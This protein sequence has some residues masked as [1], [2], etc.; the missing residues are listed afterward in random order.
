MRGFILLLVAWCVGPAWGQEFNCGFFEPEGSNT[1]RTVGTITSDSD[2]WSGTVKPLILFG[3]LQGAPDRALTGL[4]DREGSTNPGQSMANFLNS[5]HEGSL[6]HFFKEMSYETLSLVPP[7]GGV[8]LTWSESNHANLTGYG[9]ISESQCSRSIWGAGIKQFV[10]E[11]ITNADDR[12]NFRDYDGN[13]DGVVDLILVVTPRAFGDT[14]GYHGTPL[15]NATDQVISGM[16]DGVNVGRI[17]TSDYRASM[18]FFA[19]VFAHE[20]GHTMGLPELFDRTHHNEPNSTMD[21]SAGIGYWGVMSRLNWPHPRADLANTVSGASLFSVYSRMKVGW[22]TRDNDRLATIPSDEL[23]ITIYDINS[24]TEGQRDKAYKIPVN[25]SSTEYFLVANRQNQHSEESI[26]SYYNDFARGSGLAIWHIDENALGKGGSDVNEYEKHKRVDLEC[27]DGLFSDQGYPSNMPDAV[28]GGDNLDYWSESTSY[29]KNGNEG[30]ATDLWDGSSYSEFTPDTNPSTA[31]YAAQDPSVSRLIDS[32]TKQQNVFSGIYIENIAAGSNGVM[33]FDVRFAPLAPNSLE[34]AVGENQVEL[35]W[36]PP[37]DNGATIASYKVRHRLS[38]EQSWTETLLDASA[39][40]YTVTGLTENEYTFEVLAIS[41]MQGSNAGKEGL[42]ARTTATPQVAMAGPPS[43]RFD[44]NSEDMVGTYQKS[45]LFDWSLEGIDA[46]RFE[47]EGTGGSRELHFQNP[48]DFE[49]PLDTPDDGADRGD[50]IYH[51]T[52]KATPTGATREESDRYMKAV[53]VRVLDVEE[54]GK[55]TVKPTRARVDGTT[56]PPRQGEE[57]TATLTDPDGVVSINN[58]QWMRRGQH[59]PGSSKI[60]GATSLTYT[61]VARDVGHVLQAMAKYTDVRGPNKSSSSIETSVVVGRP[62]NPEVLEPVVGDGQ[63]TLTW[64]KPSDGGSPITGYE[65]QQSNDGGTIWGSEMDVDCTDETCSKELALT[66]GLYAFGVRAVNVVGLSDWVRTGPIRISALMVESQGSN[67]ELAFAEVVSGQTRSLVVETYTA[68]GVADG[69]T[70]GWSLAGA[71]VGVFTISGGVLRFATAPDY[72]MPTDASHATDED[73]N[74]VYHVTVQATAGEQTATLVVQ[75]EVTNADDPGEVTLSSTQPEVGETITATLTDP[76][77]SV[78][79]VRWSWSYFSS[80]DSPRNGEPTVVSSSDEFIPSDVLMGLR[81]QARALYADGLGTHQSAESVQTEPVVGRPSAPQNLTATPSDGS[82]VLAWDAPSLVGYPAFSGYRYRY[83][84][85]GTGWLPSA[86]GALVDQTTRPTLEEGLIH[87]KEHTV[88]VW[89]VNA[90]G[91]GPS[92]TTTATPPS[93]DTPGRVELTSRRPRVGVPLTATLVDP[94]APVRVRRWRWLQSPW[95]Y[96]SAGDS[97]LVAPSEVRYPE[98]ASYEP[99]VSAIGR[100]LRAVVDYTDQYGTPSAQSAWTAPV[101][102]GWPKAPALSATAG[103]AQVALTWTAAADQGAAIIRYQYHRSDKSGKWLDVPGDGL[104]GRYTVG[105][106]TNDADYTFKVRAVNSA[107]EGSPSNAVTAT[108]QGP[109]DPNPHAPAIAGPEEVSVAEGHIGALA[110]ATYTTSDGDDDAVT[111]TL[112]DADRG[113]FSLSSSGTLRVTSALDY[114]SDDTRYEVT[115]EAIDDGEPSKSSTKQVTVTVDNVDEVGTVTLSDPSPQ[116]GDHL[117]ATLSD[118]DGGIR[119][120][121]WYWQDISRSDESDAAEQPRTT[122]YPYTVEASDEGRRIE[123]RASYTDAHGSGKTARATT[124]VVQEAAESNRY[125]PEIAGPEE[126]SVAE[127][128]TGALADAT[129]TTSD[130]DDDQVTLTLTDADRGPFSLSSSGTLQVTSALDFESDDTR[131]EVTLEA[132]DDGEPSKSSTK[133]VTVTV[134]NQEEEGTIRLSSSSPQVGD[135]LTATLSDP[136]GG[137]RNVSWYWQDIPRSDESDAAEQPR[138]T[139]Y[140]YTVEASDEG[141][142]IEVRASYTDAHGSS[143]SARATTEVVQE[144]AESNRYAPAISGPEEVSVAEGH[145]GALADATYTTS[146]GDDDQVTLTLTD[147]DRG[148]FSLSSSGA[149]RVT[150]ALDYERDDT[151]YTVTLTATDD[152]TPSKSSTK[153]V[154]VTVTNV[155]EAGTVSLTSSSPQVGDRLTASLSDPDGYQSGGEWDWQL[156]YRQGDGDDASWVRDESVRYTADSY[157]V[158][159]SDAGRRLRAVISNYT[160]GHGSGKSAHSALTEPVQES[161]RY[162]PVISGSGSVSIN[163]GTTGSLAD[164][165]TS[166]GDGDDVTLTLTNADG[167]PFSLSSSGALRL[168]SALD[169]ESDDTRYEVTL[170]ATDDGTPSKSSTKRVEVTVD[171][172]DEAG[173][174]SLTSSS[175]RVG[176]RLTASLSDPDGYQ[177]GGSWQWLQFHGGRDGDDD[178]WEEDESVRYAADRYTV[179]SSAVGRRLRA[180]ISG[181]TDGHGSGKSAQSS[182][183]TTVQESNR[184]EPEIS[185]S[186]SVSIN[187]GTTGSLA[188]YTTSDGDGD[189]VTL[190]LT[191]ADGGPFSLSSSGALRLTSALDYERDD[192]SYTVTLTA[193]DDGTPSKSST[194]SV[195]VSIRNVDEAGTV[196]LTS[197]SPRVGD[198]LTASLSDPDGYQSGGSWQWLQ[199]RGGRDGDDDSWEEDESVRYAADRYTVPSSAVGRRLRARISGYTDGHGSG[200][201]A[202]SSLTTTVRANEPGSPG[203]FTAEPGNVYTRVDLSWS[204]AVANGSAITRYEYRYKAPSGSWSSWT[205]VGV[206]YS[207]TVSGLS[208]G[209][210]YSFEV[211]AVNGEGAGPSSSTS[212]LVRTPPAKPVSLQA[213]PDTVLSAV[214]AP[215]PFNPT[216]TIHLQVPMRGVVWLTIYNV[217]GQVVR[218]LLDDYELDAGYHSVDWDGRDQQGQPVTSGV[219][220][221]HLRAGTQ[222]LVHKLL[223]LR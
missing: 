8:D 164:Y 120:V 221:Y 207:T 20:Y 38:T 214:A 106:L 176:D 113:P 202:Q 173:T 142:R 179:P 178:S 204:A 103:D 95:Y 41:A 87:G 108:P 86:T 155:D 143:K 145:T 223:L 16:L 28:N 1:V 25:G 82:L 34:A 27:A 62:G 111:L 19:S 5:D 134:T 109:A 151:S 158:Q 172:V 123:V 23:G 65:Y 192:T 11:V 218:T 191:N 220:L 174:V 119:N 48:P 157:T 90:Q 112:T 118:P 61:P 121:S 37:S 138:T 76:D 2:Y 140:P 162:E 60:T 69:T 68:S 116:V 9:I 183:T 197:S 85:K 188:D 100:R 169:Y 194:K 199:F 33:T 195:S 83:K 101:Q 80:E 77:G 175:P 31:G 72:E 104:D 137:I 136:D 15:E 91:A 93:P 92:A 159:A 40:S 46:V 205:S 7:E 53:E 147:A 187:E 211:R 193:T 4:Q 17:I 213:L 57:L 115:L 206:A 14:C 166:D 30:D 126:V 180:R 139:S 117:T 3:K 132:I 154:A 12:I 152:G 196:S 212:S 36:K 182:L 200:K 32:S 66:P 146:D 54:Y 26:G 78:E 215:N 128:H 165:T 10:E 127:G 89:A 189:D 186:G 170:T 98:L 184:Y 209:Q 79:N 64:R 160:D 198:R 133:Q 153:Q 44:E 59:E 181:Y 102:P 51:V 18:P 45:G 88:E 144:A 22:I 129:Y 21:H 141:R 55:V 131:Y 49:N 73:G 210:R 94:D 125:A 70:V 149:L 58:W 177:S 171:N 135:H 124:E 208:S 71:D 185:G 148:P 47:L 29:N 56:S 99:T 168:T 6:A 43:V 52:V 63:V 81:L 67:P 96:R 219:Y 222:A 201:S 130:G 150:S 163:E 110:D 156:W 216:T 190:T 97:S 75:V 35:T 24:T 203:N 105:G 13:T 42:A 50:N 167:G 114:E 84:A 107:G 217:A 122:S 74:N 161:N 39:R